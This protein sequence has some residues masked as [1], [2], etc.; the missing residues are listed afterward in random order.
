MPQKLTRERLE[1][2]K[3]IYNSRPAT[4]DIHEILDQIDVVLNE[5]ITHAEATVD[6]K[7]DAA[8]EI[9]FLLVD[10]LGAIHETNSK[11]REL[12]TAVRQS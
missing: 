2:I 7:K 3:A 1:E 12:Q 4:N 5:L 6:E 10:I 9:P 8:K 11:L